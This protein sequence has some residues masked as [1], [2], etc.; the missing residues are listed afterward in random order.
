VFEDS[1]SREPLVDIMYNI[2]LKGGDALIYRALRAVDARITFHYVLP[3]EEGE[4]KE[5]VL[6]ETAK[7]PS[8][9]Y[10]ENWLQ[11]EFKGRDLSEYDVFI[12]LEPPIAKEW[13]EEKRKSGPKHA[14]ATRFAYTAYGNEPYAATSYASIC[15]IASVPGHNLKRK[16]QLHRY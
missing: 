13:N 10:V 11:H 12:A 1:F 15:M 2:K 9:G 14:S 3:D 5:Y 6:E 7:F 8:E 16:L 4:D